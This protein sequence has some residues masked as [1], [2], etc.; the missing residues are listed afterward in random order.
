MVYAVGAILLFILFL[1][2]RALLFRPYPQVEVQPFAMD[3]D[4]ERAVKN[5]AQMVRCRT[6][7]HDDVSLED[8]AEFDKFRQLLQESYPLIHQH[9]E[10]RQVGRK[11]LLY[12]WPGKSS[13]DPTV[14]M[15]HYDVV[16]AADEDWEHPPF[17]GL[18]IDNHLWGRGTLDTKS[19]LCA[20]M[21]AA[22]HLLGQ[23]FVPERDIYLSFAGDEEVNGAGAADIVDY[24]E[25]HGVRPHMVLDEGGAI[26]EGAVPGVPGKYALVGT[27]EKGKLH[28][29]LTLK[30]K[31]G[32]ASTP[33]PHS[34]VGVLARAVCKVE[35]KP[36]K[37]HLAGPVRE[38]FDILGRHAAFALKLFYANL[39]L[40]AP[41][42]NLVARKMG[43]EINALVR[44]TVAFTKMQ[45]S[46]AVNVFPPTASVEADVRLMEGSTSQS[47]IRDL[48]K[49]IGNEAVQLEAIETIE[50]MP[51]TKI[52][53]EPWRR[54]EEG[55]LQIWPGT[56]VAP[57]L[58][59][60]ASDARQFT[61]ICDNVLRFSGMELTAEERRMIHGANERIP[62]DK[63][64]TTVKF[65]TCMMLKS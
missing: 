15:A 55:I 42:L 48:K 22:E 32:H 40:F 29:R 4:R 38:M 41:L 36:L 3:V 30:G 14:F 46:E 5:L 16:P 23:G 35:S 10:F 9:C 2:V 12:R 44:T 7:S 61:R 34:P 64:E 26:V 24:L 39:G 18:V 6:V 59:L 56:L 21:E 20:I 28:L 27:G 58:M 19:T 31:G 47:V 43:G 45:A 13:G 60:A 33:P 49:R 52:G 51:F 8:E 11:G 57:Y 25:A 62:L 37:F 63:L 65:F 50:V 54:L 17:A 1:V 53:T